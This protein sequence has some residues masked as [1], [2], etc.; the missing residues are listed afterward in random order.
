MGDFSMLEDIREMYRH[1]KAT[2]DKDMTAVDFVTD[3]L[4]N[5]DGV[6]DKHENGDNQKPHSPIQFQHHAQSTFILIT[7]FSYPIAKYFPVNLKPSSHLV[8]FHTS[9]YIAKFFHPPIA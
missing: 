5:I 2:E 8:N 6:F 4:L 1:C 3:H 7:E 9:G